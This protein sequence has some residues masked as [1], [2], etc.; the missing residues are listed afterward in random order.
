MLH[1]Y[2]RTTVFCRLGSEQ[3]ELYHQL[4]A[5]AYT[6]TQRVMAGIEASQCFGCTLVPFE[7]RSPALGRTKNVAVRE[8]TAE[9]YHVYVVEGF[10]SAGKV[11]HVYIAYVE[12][13]HKE[14]VGH[15]AVAVDTFFTYDCG[16]DARGGAAA[17]SQVAALEAAVEVGAQAVVDRL[18]AE[19]VA[20]LGGTFGFGL[21]T[22]EQI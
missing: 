9:D 22:V 21:Q 8:T 7:A 10:A 12:A 16:T 1:L 11:G 3:V 20:A 6:E 17:N 19:I 4:A 15:L 2:G 18:Q 14:R 5:I 13:G